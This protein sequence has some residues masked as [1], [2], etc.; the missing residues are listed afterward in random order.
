ME[1]LAVVAPA[2]ATLSALAGTTG[3]IVAATALRRNREDQARRD[4]AGLHASAYMAA[5]RYSEGQEPGADEE[6]SDR[7][8]VWLVAKVTNASAHPYYAV[9]T[10]VFLRS[11]QKLYAAVADI[12]PPNSSRYARLTLV[13]GCDGASMDSDTLV[14]TTFIDSQDRGW[15]RNSQGKLDRCKINR[16]WRKA[17][18]LARPHRGAALHQIQELPEP[19]PDGYEVHLVRDAAGHEVEVSTFQAP[20]SEKSTDDEAFPMPT[21][22]PKNGEHLG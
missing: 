13:D 22:Q 12:V 10:S 11:R 1:W 9:V 19:S 14:T 5:Q 17:E 2:A 21:W 16:K 15:R 3:A 6:P 18:L 20:E 8:D 7:T 4:A